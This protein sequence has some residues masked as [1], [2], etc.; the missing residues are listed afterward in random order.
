M[1]TSY[2]EIQSHILHTPTFR[3]SWSC[4]VGQEALQEVVGDAESSEDFEVTLFGWRRSCTIILLSCILVPGRGHIISLPLVIKK[5]I[6]ASP[7][8]A[9][10][11]FADF[12]ILIKN[13][14]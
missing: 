9:R 13:Q 2:R 6:G 4:L 8:L 10:Q 1:P 7:S 3:Y 14:E 12:I 5:L 11:G